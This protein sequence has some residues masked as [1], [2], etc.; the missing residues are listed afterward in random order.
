MVLPVFILVIGGT[1]DLGRLFFAYVSTEN[2]AKEGAIYGA[3][4]PRCNQPK[5]G[6]S[7]PNTVRW[8]VVNELTDVSAVSHSAECLRGGVSIPV[9]LCAEG[10]TYRVSVSHTFTLLTPILTPVLGNNIQLTSRASAVV[11]NAAF[12][13]N[14]PVSPVPGQ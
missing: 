11:F 10:D 5:L 7:D 1:V 4:N 14:L 12:D 8:H 3:I 2:A 6:C 13:P 9:E